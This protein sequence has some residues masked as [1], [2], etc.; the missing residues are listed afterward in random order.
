MSGRKRRWDSLPSVEELMRERT[1][2]RYRIRYRRALRSTLTTIITVAAIAII[3]SYSLMPVLRIYGHS[4]TPTVHDGNIVLAVRSANFTKGDVVAFYYNNKILVKRVIAGPGEWVDID[5]K[6]QVYVNE[7]P[8]DEPYIDALAYGECNIELPYQ[9]P[10]NRWFVM[11]DKRS[12]SI[13]SRNTSV[14][15][16]SDE[17]IV[18]RIFAR[19]WPLNEAGIVR[20]GGVP[21]PIASL[22]TEAEAR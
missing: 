21:S 8:I 14:G 19:I 9:V 4:M 20:R 12:V 5:E 11:G 13:D 22:V 2:E 6:G 16:V 15:C 3:I 1:H 18:G 7:E 10:E 17:Q